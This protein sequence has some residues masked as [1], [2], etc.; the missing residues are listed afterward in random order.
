MKTN[1]TTATATVITGLTEDQAARV[2][3]HGLADKFRKLATAKRAAAA[4][5]LDPIPVPVATIC[6]FCA[7]DD[8]APDTMIGDLPACLTCRDNASAAASPAETAADL[9]ELADLAE[10]STI[11]DWAADLADLASLPEGATDTDPAFAGIPVEVVMDLPE[12]AESYIARLQGEGA[13]ADTETTVPRMRAGVAALNGTAKG[14]PGVNNHAMVRPAMKAAGSFAHAVYAAGWAPGEV[15]TAHMSSGHQSRLY[16]ASPAIGGRHVIADPEAQALAGK[17]SSVACAWLSPAGQA[18]LVVSV[19]RG[20][21]E[22][23]PELFD[24]LSSGIMASLT[25]ERAANRAAYGM[26]PDPM[27]D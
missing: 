25:E 4:D 17:S 1:S 24:C 27:A 13:A 22:V 14:L 3:F 19:G 26:G 11:E 23:Q 2:T 10:A 9:A 12:T 18:G 21:W 6:A 7:W 15:I 16:Q 5:K 20:R 8:A